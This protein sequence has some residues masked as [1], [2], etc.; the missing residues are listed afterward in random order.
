MVRKLIILCITLWLPAVQAAS[1]TAEIDRQQLTTEESATLTLQLIN[2]DTRLRAE[3]V[4]P[5][6]D[7]SILSRDFAVGIPQTDFRYNIAQ[8]SGRSTS[9]LKV[10][11]FPKHSGILN[12]PSFAVDGLRTKALTLDVKPLAA[13][14]APEAFVRAHLST[15]EP[16]VHQQLVIY[17]D[18]YHRVPLDGATLGST[19]ETEPTRIELLPN[20][21]LPRTSLKLRFKGFNYDVERL[22]WAI[23]P[24]KSG[25]FAVQTPIVDLIKAGGKPQHIQ[26]QRLEVNIKALP[27]DVPDNI[28]VGK[29][30]LGS[31]TLPASTKQNEAINWTL[32]LSAPVAVSSLPDYLPLPEFPAA[33]KLYPDRA[34]H[35]N[36]KTNDGITD[37]ATYT[38]SIMPLEAGNFVIPEIQIPYFDPMRGAVDTISLPRHTINISASVLPSPAPATHNDSAAHTN[39]SPG[40]TDNSTQPWQVATG[41]VTLLW[42]LTLGF[43]LNLWRK[44]KTVAAP[45][46]ATPQAS[47]A[48]KQHANEHPLQQQL[49]QAFGS[50]TLEQGLA[51]WLEEF[52]N[53]NDALEVVRA[54]QRLCYGHTRRNSVTEPQLTERVA[55][56]CTRILRTDRTH[57]TPIDRWAPEA[58]TAA[59]HEERS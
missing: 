37:R 47:P 38:L 1:F 40:S 28:I 15:T 11:L 4:D 39:T 46:V 27:A 20:W 21:E 58:F 29:P 33:L 9:E 50:R 24:D 53:D 5:N 44:F 54:V 3:G 49:L 42:L 25:K 31:S 55:Q 32:N 2:S 14:Y 41:L 19:L 18:V 23:F 7:L 52:P 16:W 36:T 17:L 22:A 10:E 34:H 57:K 13:D 45:V 8:G 59:P 43:T 35:D 48:L 26:S 30:A 12:I 6:I 56:L 51:R